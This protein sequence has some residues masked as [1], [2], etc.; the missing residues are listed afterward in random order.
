MTT[1]AVAEMIDELRDDICSIRTTV[2]HI[3]DV[4][5]VDLSGMSYDDERPVEQLPPAASVFGTIAQQIHD[6]SLRL[7][8]LNE[9][10]V[11]V[12]KAVTIPM[13]TSGTAT[14]AD[15]PEGSSAGKTN[16]RV[17][18]FYSPAAMSKDGILGPGF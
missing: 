5:G 12:A 9:A 6:Q 18:D 10:A 1:T 3:A 7:R 13:G 11:Y 2:E 15:I 4:L 17:R 8:M 16:R 14:D